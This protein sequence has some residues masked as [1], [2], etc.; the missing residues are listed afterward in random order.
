MILR[1]SE[2][3]LGDAVYATFD[4]YQIWLRTG[5]GNDNRIALEPSVMD[6]LIAYWNAL[7][8]RYS[9]ATGPTTE[10]G[11]QELPKPFDPDDEKWMP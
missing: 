10:S 3:Y 8:V 4:G 11:A 5:D 1:E 2:T 6:R 9:T 7:G